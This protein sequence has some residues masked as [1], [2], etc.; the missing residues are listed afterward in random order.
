MCS[1]SLCFRFQW[2]VSSARGK[3][4]KLRLARGT[5]AARWAG[6]TPAS[7]SLFPEC[8][9]HPGAEGEGA[10]PGEGRSLLI[11]TFEAARAHT[12]SGESLTAPQRLVENHN[13]VKGSREKQLL[14]IETNINKV[15][16]SR[17]S[18]KSRPLPW[19]RLRTVVRTAEV[20]CSQCRAPFELHH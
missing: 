5:G 18:I 19:Q 15:D 7:S 14:N 11:C 3:G 16:W 10:R 4:R 12:H 6:P 8:R 20:P 9:A 1:F 2:G 13:S 17:W